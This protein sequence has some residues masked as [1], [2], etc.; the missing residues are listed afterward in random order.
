[1]YITKDCHDKL[2]V[3]VSHNISNNFDDVS[4]LIEILEKCQLCY[5]RK[6]MKTT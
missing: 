2:Q 4:E 6:K 1:M 5:V 3:I